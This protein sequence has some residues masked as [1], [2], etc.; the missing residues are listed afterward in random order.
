MG[1][2]CVLLG[3]ITFLGF[4]GLG[5]LAANALIDYKVTL[6]ANIT[7]LAKISNTSVMVGIICVFAFVGLLIGLNL[8]MN[9]L[10][11]NKVSKMYRMARRKANK[12]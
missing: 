4:T 9:G 6:S 10:I 5:A 1:V 3:I 8:I 7:A 2:I 12:G 11:Y